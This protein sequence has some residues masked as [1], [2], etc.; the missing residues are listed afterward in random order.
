MATATSSK[1]MKVCIYGAGAIGGWLGVKLAGPGCDVSV[2]ARGAT[3][4]ALAANGLRLQEGGHAHAVA[5]RASAQPAERNRWRR[6][7]ADPP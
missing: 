1:A 2:V 7:R 3:L 5:V 4:D 6:A